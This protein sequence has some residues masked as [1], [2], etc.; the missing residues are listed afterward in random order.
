MLREAAYYSRMTLGVYRMSRVE[1]EKDPPG[2]IQR[3]IENR[4]QNFLDLMRRVV[5]AN[6]AN[7]Y[8]SLFQWAGCTLGD[9]ERHA[10]RDG[11]DTTLERLR[12]AGVYLSHDEFK[13]KR[14]IERS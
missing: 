3:M 11:L 1:L 8:Y 10:S 5:F 9:L 14:P 4:E 12:E 6:P 7:P 2:V 13:G